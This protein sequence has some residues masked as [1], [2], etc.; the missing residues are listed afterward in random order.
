MIQ[1]IKQFI[2]E[3]NMI[4]KGDH[5][6]LGVS[7]GADSVCLLHV[8]LELKDELNFTIEVCHVEHG[9]R[10]EESRE[11]AAFT[12]N[13]CRKLKVPFNEFSV[14]VPGYSKETGLGD[15][16]AARILRYGIFNERAEKTNGK[17]ALAHHMDDNAE[18][19]LF[20]MLRGS[21]IKGLSGMQPVRDI[22]IRPLL[23][24][25]RSMIEEYLE[26]IGQ[27]YCID[28]TNKD[29]NYSRNLIRLSVIP[30]LLSINSKAIEHI[31]KSALMLS[32]VDDYLLSQ[33]DKE[34]KRIISYKDDVVKI[35]ADKLNNLPKVMAGEILLR[36]ME[37]IAGR[38]KD[39][40]SAHV[41]AVMEL[42]QNQSGKK[43]DL[44]YEITGYKEYNKIILEKK[45]DNSFESK[46][47]HFISKEQLQDC[48]NNHR[49]ILIP[50]EEPHA[51]LHISVRKFNGKTQEIP[52]NSYTKWLSY[53]K[54]RSGFQ[55]RK[56]R[57][58]DY[59]VNDE[60]GHHKKLKD[61]FINEKIPASK[62]DMI[63]LV[64][65][66][67]EVLSILDLNGRISQTYK[68]SEDT[69]EILELRYDGGN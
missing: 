10:G 43:I 26:S 15:E 63:W 44:P 58:R 23:C 9:I 34:A 1:K 48:R 61:F 4:D 5:I 12:R 45:K 64:T 25:R 67:S 3:N 66:E 69:L 24:V 42:A 41:A 28:S 29:T 8:L 31:N 11:D 21:G 60:Y 7:G 47:I 51:T 2:E 36:G 6:I 49:Q 54:I 65:D 38:R 18:T 19:V 30:D 39:L 32:E 57:A 68:V 20:Q 55:I 59:F 16:E 52:K 50:L 22:Y 53:D 14:D 27:D 62:R 13:L 33:T 40:T 37:K 35:D 56:R 46:Q 17:V